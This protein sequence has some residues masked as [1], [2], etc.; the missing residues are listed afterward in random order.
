[1]AT[2]PHE[3]AGAQIV[4]HYTDVA[5][6]QPILQAG[7]IRPAAPDK[8]KKVKTAVWFSSNPV[9][10]PSANRMWRNEHGRIVRLG[11]DQTYVLGGGLARIGVARAVAPL[12]WKTYK[13]LSG[14]SAEQAKAIYDDAVSAGA[15]PGE[16]FATFDDVPRAQWLAVEVLEDEVWTP[17]RG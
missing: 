11:K 3:S 2:D 8:A 1:M 10:E 17:K 7:V 14:I 4:W 5:R 12:D 6:L 15:R 16:W 13:H 9:W